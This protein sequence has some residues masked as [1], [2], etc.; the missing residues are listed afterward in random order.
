MTSV[1]QLSNKSFG[2]WS[3][4]ILR[5]HQHSQAESLE[6]DQN[7]E[8]GEGAHKDRVESNQFCA[9]PVAQ[10]ILR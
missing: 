4:F 9:N 6:L 1:C 10:T 7:L 3:I 5:T 8:S 2:T